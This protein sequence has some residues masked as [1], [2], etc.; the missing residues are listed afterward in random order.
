MS[1]ENKCEHDWEFYALMVYPPIPMR[2]CRKCNYTLAESD[3]KEIQAEKVEDNQAVNE[4][5]FAN[6]QIC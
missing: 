3:W 1:E 2:R 6:I 4:T 5:D